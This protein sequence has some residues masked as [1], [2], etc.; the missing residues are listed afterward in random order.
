MSHPP[1][2]FADWQQLAPAAAARTLLERVAL[3]S[4]AQRR[5]VVATLATEEQLTAQF[6]VAARTGPLG[7]VPYFLKD[8]FDVAGQPTLA[9][10]TFLPEVRPAPAR[11]SAVVRALHA[12]GAVLAGKAHLHEFAYGLTGENAHY[13]DCE[14]PHFPGRTTGG[15]SSGSAAVVAAGIVPFSIGTD[16]GG[17]IRVPAAFCGLYGFRMRPHHPWIADGFPLAPSL[18]TAGWFTRTAGDMQAALA[19][20][21]GPATGASPA[22][23]CWLEMPGLDA[24]VAVAFRAAAAG[25]APSADAAT[26]AALLTGFAALTES[27]VVLGGHEAWAVHQGWADRYATRYDPT[28]WARLQHARGLQPAQLAAAEGRIAQLRETWRNY[29]S[30]HDFLILPASPSPALTKADCT[31]ANR[32][33][34]LTLTTPVS[35]GGWPALVVPVELPSGLTT[36]LQII[37][38]DANSRIFRDILG[39][40]QAS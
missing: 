6:A 4:P 3:L 32:L 40:A 19:M 17:S 31:P 34:L 11:D 5:A 37:A 21:L 27:Y 30:N 36:G 12:A 24:E 29:F 39:A 35:L 2:T 1:L 18:D 8:L 22:R 13:G 7:G 38:P 14:H 10:S 28:V 20:L 23:G 33:R 16:T 9:G 25:L 15:S 26:Q